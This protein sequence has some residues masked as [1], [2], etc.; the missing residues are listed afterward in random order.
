MADTLHPEDEPLRSSTDELEDFKES[1]VWH[2]IKQFLEDRREIIHE[3][4]KS[5]DSIEEL[6]KLQ[7]AL[8]HI[9]DMLDLPDKF[10]NELEGGTYGQ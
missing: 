3:K 5:V 7:G 8:E 6:R 9:E 2:D 1:R 10:L 4:M